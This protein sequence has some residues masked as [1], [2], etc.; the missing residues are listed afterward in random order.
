MTIQVV[1]RIEELRALLHDDRAAG[2]SV[3]FVPTMGYLHEGHASL[4]RRAHAECDVATATIFVN[5]IKFAPT[6]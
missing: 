1:T 5:N 6:E 3:G 2:R 4:M